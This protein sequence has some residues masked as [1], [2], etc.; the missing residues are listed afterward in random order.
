MTFLA[1][2]IVCILIWASSIVVPSGDASNPTNPTVELPLDFPRLVWLALAGAVLSISRLKT[3][4]VVLGCAIAAGLAAWGSSGLVG[5]AN[6][7]QLA[8][9]YEVPK[10]IEYWLPVM[11]AVGA[12]GAL[13]AVNRLRRLG[14]LRFVLVGVFLVV[15]VFPV[16]QPLATNV[17]IGEHR[18]AESVGLAFREA[19]LGYWNFNGYPDSR[20]II[21][22]PRQQVVDELK[23]EERAGR[24]GPSTR[25]LN[26]AWWFQQWVAT[27]V[28]V[29]TGAMETS[30]SLHPE[31][32]IHTEGGRLYGFDRLDRELATDYGYVVLAP[33]GLTA[34]L[35]SQTVTSIT[36]SGYHE[37][38]SNS[39]AIIYARD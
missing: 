1:T 2:A 24:L 22:G 16:T 19:Q 5:S 20:T 30:I 33:G 6:L 34:D 12:A 29:F 35:V 25:V 11:L 31:L 10:T 27:P 15:T 21:D 8:V 9:H 36:S 32:S 4:P 3:G 39:L 14:A 23:A 7:T 38:W 37:I 26:I 28:G 18:A 17:Q 13:A